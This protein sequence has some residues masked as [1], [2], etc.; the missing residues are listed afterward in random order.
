MAIF[1]PGPLVGAISGNLAGQNFFQ[2][3]YGPAIRRRLARTDKRT[4][5]QLAQR[6]RFQSIA[7]RWHALTDQQRDAWRAYARQLKQPNRL[8]L[9]RSLSGF[10]AYSAHTLFFIQKT[11]GPPLDI[12]PLDACPPFTSLTLAFAQGGPYTVDGATAAGPVTDYVAVYG[13]RPVSS[14]PRTAFHNWRFLHVFRPATMPHDVQPEWDAILGPLRTTEVVAVTALTWAG[15]R[16][17]SFPFQ[18]TTTVT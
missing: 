11:P 5:A 13:S 3:S 2:S 9:P 10:Q 14:K 1:R 17:R 12:P 6:A 18:E 15:A 7:S 4:Q 16:R 8:G